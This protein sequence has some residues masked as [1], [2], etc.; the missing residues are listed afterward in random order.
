MAYFM[1]SCFEKLNNSQAAIVCKMASEKPFIT[2]RDVIERLRISVNQANYLL[3]K[4]V[5]A[6]DLKIMNHGRY[7]KYQIVHKEA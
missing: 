6:G 5:A 3:K 7:S 2:K 1:L 4:M